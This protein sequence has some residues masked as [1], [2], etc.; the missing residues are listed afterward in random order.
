MLGRFR[1]LD[2]N[3]WLE[4]VI[5]NLEYRFGLKSNREN[6]VSFEQNNDLKGMEFLGKI[7][8]AAVNHTPIEITYLSF[9]GKEFVNILHPYHVKQFNNRW[10]L[11]GMEEYNGIKQISNRALDRITKISFPNVPFVENTFVDFSTYFD[12]IYGVTHPGTD[13]VEE[14]IVLRFDPDRFPYVLN[15][16]IHPTQ[17]IIDNST[18]ILSVSLRPNKEFES[19][20]FSYGPQV[21]VISPLWLRMQISEKMKETLKK[22]STVQKECTDDI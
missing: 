11:F 3:S 16:P 7:I 19:R 5:S 2:N 14:V 20:L 15:K 8:D 6:I 22:Y 17:Q 18:C 21:E 13:V 10:F 12:N 9:K 1:G 4:E